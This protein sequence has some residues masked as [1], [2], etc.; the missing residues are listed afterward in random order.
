MRE[1]RR[2]S[3]S[4]SVEM[5]SVLA[6]PGT[7][8]NR[9]CPRANSAISSWSMTWRWPMIRFSISRRI[10]WRASLISATAASVSSS[11]L[12]AE[13]FSGPTVAGTAA[14]IPEGPEPAA[15]AASLGAATSD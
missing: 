14:S 10:A 2:L 4:D 11:E 8:T 13:P 15:E 5:S 7:P 1:K 12:G 9:Q 3:T 6:S